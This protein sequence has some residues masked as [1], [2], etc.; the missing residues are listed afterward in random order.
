MSAPSR[1]HAAARIG[2]IRSASGNGSVVPVGCREGWRR[3]PFC[4]TAAGSRAVPSSA[5]YLHDRTLSGDWGA[6][7]HDSEGT[8]MPS[9]RRCGHVRIRA[10]VHTAVLRTTEANLLAHHGR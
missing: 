10:R 7:E 5:P 6:G 1:V 8:V 3:S 9:I 4:L 2:G